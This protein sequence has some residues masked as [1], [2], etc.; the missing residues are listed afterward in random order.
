M[1]HRP[2]VG[3]GA[4]RTSLIR[5]H[6]LACDVLA[7]KPCHGSNQKPDSGGLLLFGQNLGIGR[8]CRIVDGDVS[9]F[10]ARTACMPQAPLSR[11]PVADAGKPSQLFD[12]DMDYFAGLVPLVMV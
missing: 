3:L 12:F 5:Q 1:P 11:D 2:A 10:V 8:P 7:A 4:L 9:I 6:L